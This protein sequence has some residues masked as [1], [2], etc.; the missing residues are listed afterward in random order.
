MI[1]ARTSLALKALGDHL[2]GGGPG[3]LHWRWRV[4]VPVRWAWKVMFR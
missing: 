1:A 2:A 4:S 3:A